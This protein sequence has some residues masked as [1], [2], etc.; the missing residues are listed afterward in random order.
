MVSLGKGGREETVKQR[1]VISVP[2]S[3]LLTVQI[4][5]NF[6]Y[7]STERC[8]LYNYGLRNVTSVFTACSSFFNELF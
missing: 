7:A 8:L 2:N 1:L 3:V 4:E 5:N 6:E